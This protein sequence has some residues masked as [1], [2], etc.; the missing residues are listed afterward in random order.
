MNTM[1][2]VDAREEVMAAPL[3]Q[4]TFVPSSSRPP[5]HVRPLLSLPPMQRAPRKRSLPRMTAIWGY[6]LFLQGTSE[7]RPHRQQS[8]GAAA[9]LGKAVTILGRSIRAEMRPPSLP[10]TPVHPMLTEAS[11]RL[12]PMS[13]S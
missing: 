13:L 2:D 7:P 12:F 5:R 4:W 11:H 8:D 1:G 6:L 3:S 10:V 9:P